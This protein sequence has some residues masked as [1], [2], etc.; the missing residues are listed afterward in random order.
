MFQKKKK[1][2]KRVLQTNL[3]EEGVQQFLLF[4]APQF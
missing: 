2:K 4:L 3:E 1:K